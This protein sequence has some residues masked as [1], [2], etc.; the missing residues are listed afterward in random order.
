MYVSSAV[1]SSSIFDTHSA[2]PEIAPLAE[3]R[4]TGA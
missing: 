3:P 2:F 1:Y 4:M